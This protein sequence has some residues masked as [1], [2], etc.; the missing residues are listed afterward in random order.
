MAA[1][2]VAGW[3]V[4]SQ[5]GEGRVHLKNELCG[6]S[7]RTSCFTP[8]VW[9]LTRGSCSS[10][11]A[12]M[13]CICGA[14]SLTP[15]RC[16]RWKPRPGRRSTRNSWKGELEYRRWGWG[17]RV[18][19]YKTDR[20]SWVA[21]DKD[22]SRSATSLWVRCVCGPRALAH[23]VA[24][25][26]KS[27]WERK[28]H[29]SGSDL[30]PV[31]SALLSAALRAGPSRMRASKVTGLLWTAIYLQRGSPDSSPLRPDLCIG[32]SKLHREHVCM[33]WAGKRGVGDLLEAREK[34]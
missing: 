6:V 25:Y 19:W 24:G 20:V 18:K 3:S 28:N 5:L 4:C 29:S 15:S 11:W 30:W 12:T 16:N 14:G 21:L 27:Q 17:G 10:A 31:R 9:E 23:S 32:G 34:D 1:T 2:L 26:L 13:N 7:S 22:T 33:L 8:L